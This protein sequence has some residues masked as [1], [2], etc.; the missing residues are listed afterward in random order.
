MFDT[1][2]GELKSSNIIV[3]LSVF[4]FSSVRFSFLFFFF[5]KACAHLVLLGLFVELTF[6]LSKYSLFVP[7]IRLLFLF[8]CVTN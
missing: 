6:L 1:K 8:F 4:P 5:F 2:V 7:C 3:D